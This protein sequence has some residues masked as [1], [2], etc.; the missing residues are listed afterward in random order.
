MSL[1]SEE[2][3]GPVLPVTPFST[4]EEAISL[5]NDSDFGLAASVWGR[6]AH[7]TAVARRI[8]AGTVMV[9]DL[10]SGFAI[11]AAPHGGLKHSGI[12]R[13]HGRLG[14]Q[15]LVRPR[16]LDVDLA[17]RMKKPWWYPYSGRFVPLSAFADMVYASGLRQRLAAA[18]RSLPALFHPRR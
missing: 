3:F 15:E 5:A 10:I 9:N 11:S 1:M 13:T 8:D 4:D 17:P 14:L 7:A 6:T 16:Y 2:T 12:G 18:L